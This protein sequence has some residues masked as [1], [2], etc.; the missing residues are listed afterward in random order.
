MVSDRGGDLQK[1]PF[2]HRH[3]FGIFG[4]VCIFAVD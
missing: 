4:K 1:S 2:G 3:V